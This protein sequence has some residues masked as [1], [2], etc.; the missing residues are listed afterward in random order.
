MVI[1]EFAMVVGSW[2]CGTAV[3]LARPPERDLVSRSVVCVSSLGA[4]A[5]SPLKLITPTAFD[6]ILAGNAS[7][8]HLPR[9]PIVFV[10]PTL[11]NA[12]PASPDSSKPI[13]RIPVDDPRVEFIYHPHTLQPDTQSHDT[14]TT[15]P[16]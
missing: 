5:N 16:Y 10:I 11:E 1:I 14:F 15:P 7:G 8:F 13:H 12:S 2:K 3:S 9:S 4:T 6:A